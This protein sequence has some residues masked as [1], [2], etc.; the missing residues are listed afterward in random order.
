MNNDDVE[1][2]LAVTVTL[3]EAKIYLSKNKHPMLSTQCKFSI[4][5]SMLMDAIVGSRRR[6]EQSEQHGKTKGLSCHTWMRENDEKK[7]IDASTTQEKKA[8]TLVW[9]NARSHKVDIH[10]HSQ[11]YNE[12]SVSGELSYMVDAVMPIEGIIEKV[13]E[14]FASSTRSVDP[15]ACSTEGVTKMAAAQYQLEKQMTGFLYHHRSQDMNW[16]ES[17][18]RGIALADIESEWQNYYGQPLAPTL[19]DCKYCRRNT[20]TT[21][22]IQVVIKRIQSSKYFPW[23]KIATTGDAETGIWI[24]PSSKTNDDDSAPGA[25]AAPVDTNLRRKLKNMKILKK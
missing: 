17:E 9:H 1:P 23:C 6:K 14:E 18:Y 12:D 25:D 8:A 7:Q 20:E 10:K 22:V 5:L 13:A 2:V 3:C 11:I 21:T 15:S 16:P 4:D 19:A 24:R